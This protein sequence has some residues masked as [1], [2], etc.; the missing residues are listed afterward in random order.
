M[1]AAF[2][3]SLPKNSQ[4]TVIVSTRLVPLF[5][6]SFPQLDIVEGTTENIIN[7]NKQHFDAYCFMGCLPR[8]LGKAIPDGSAFLKSKQ[9]LRVN[10]HAKKWP[11]G[12]SWRGGIGVEGERRSIDLKLYSPILK[13]PEVSFVNLQYDALPSE[14]ESLQADGID[15]DY[16]VTINALENIDTFASVVSSCDIVITVDNSTAH[17]AAALGIS[18]WVLLPHAPNWRW[19]KNANSSYWYQSTTLFRQSDAGEWGDVI[20]RIAL[21][22]RER[23]N[24]P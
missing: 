19:Q 12:L 7:L 8:I 13:I 4:Y 11:V 10:K 21:Q 2:F 23:V 17:L 5:T 16:D 6:R 18:T 22:L 24:P 9:Y 20:Q 15:I 14:I 3:S 1:F